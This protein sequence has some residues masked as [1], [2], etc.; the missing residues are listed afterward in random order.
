MLAD[1]NSELNVGHATRDGEDAVSQP[2][3]CK[4]IERVGVLCRI[5]A[6]PAPQR[7]IP[8]YGPEA[9]PPHRQDTRGPRKPLNPKPPHSVVRRFL[10]RKCPPAVVAECRRHDAIGPVCS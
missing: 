7:H 6:L 10:L 2:R 5:G 3:A 4:G 1:G 8:L 9:Q